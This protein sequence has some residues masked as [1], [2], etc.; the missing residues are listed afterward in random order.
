MTGNGPGP[1]GPAAPSR[2]ETFRAIAPVVFL[3]VV[4]PYVVFAVLRA[5]GVRPVVALSL[6]AAVTVVVIAARAIRTRTL[7][8]LATF[9]LITFVIGIAASFISGDPRL[10]L[11][12]ES[13][14]SGIIGILLLGTTL[15]GKPLPFY[16]AQQFMGGS[17]GGWWE[18]RWSNSSG[19]R[20]AFRVISIVWGVALLADAVVRVPVVYAVPLNTA[21][22]LSPVIF[23][24][25]L[26]ALAIWTRR[27]VISARRRAGQTI[28]AG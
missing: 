7:D 19:F 4:L 15:V 11:T 27:Y 25:V 18:E 28:S 14:Y 16:F 22:V 1:S 3:D 23:V 6:G 12:R 10:V 8:R 9:I 26:V 13:V 5:A 17:G 24:V 21:A 2:R 20:H